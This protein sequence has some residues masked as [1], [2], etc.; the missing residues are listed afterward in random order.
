VEARVD[1]KGFGFLPYPFPLLTGRIE[2]MAGTGQHFSGGGTL[3]IVIIPRVLGLCEGSLPIL[4]CQ[5]PAVIVRYLR[6]LAFE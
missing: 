2:L 4:L 6:H 5:K 3:G 1:L